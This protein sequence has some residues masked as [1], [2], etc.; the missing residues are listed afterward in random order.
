[1]SAAILGALLSSVAAFPRMDPA[2]VEA[3]KRNAARKAAGCPY[4]AKREAEP[5]AEPRSECPFGEN[6]KRAT[7][8]AAQQ[9]V[10]VD[11]EHA[12]QAPDIA[13]GDQRGTPV[14]SDLCESSPSPLF[15]D[16]EKS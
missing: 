6:K 10:N 14:C 15:D 5:E 12:W 11:G 8:N 9:K 7:F 3:L 16:G 2:H 13:G 4:A 1:M